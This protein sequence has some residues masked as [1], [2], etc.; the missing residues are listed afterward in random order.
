MEHIQ[1]QRGFRVIYECDFV[2]VCGDC[3]IDI[4]VHHIGNPRTSLQVRSFFFLRCWWLFS[5]SETCWKSLFGKHL[6]PLFFCFFFGFLFF[7]PY[8][9]P[10][11]ILLWKTLVAYNLKYDISW[12]YLG[13]FLKKS[14]LNLRFFFYKTTTLWSSPKYN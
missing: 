12:I 14:I 3:N 4:N 7:V 1:N 11:F 10:S 2:W 8:S 5:V 9:F 13:L 6:T